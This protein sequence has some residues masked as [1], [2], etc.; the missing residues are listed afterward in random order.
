MPQLMIWCNNLNKYINLET[1][2]QIMHV[3]ARFNLKENGK[4]AR[5]VCYL[6]MEYVESKSHFTA[7][8]TFAL[9]NNMIAFAQQHNQVE[10][11]P[12]TYAKSILMSL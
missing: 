3:D 4:Q 11:V 7:H 9:T 12:D 8:H 2:Q 6:E 1:D 10:K 5:V